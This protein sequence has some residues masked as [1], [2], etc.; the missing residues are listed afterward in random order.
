MTNEVCDVLA[1]RLVA[2]QDEADMAEAAMRIT[3]DV[4]GN[5]GYGCGCCGRGCGELGCVMVGWQ[6]ASGSWASQTVLRLHLICAYGSP[7]SPPGWGRSTRPSLPTQA[8]PTLPA[9]PNSYDFEARKYGPCELLEIVPPLLGEF[10]LRGTN[11]L[12]HLQHAV[13]PWLREARLYKQHVKVG[14]GWRGAANA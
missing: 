2:G 1:A 5:T 11:P 13:M 3:L 8:T 10:T 6:A 4:I 9:C 7:P 14:W 12:R